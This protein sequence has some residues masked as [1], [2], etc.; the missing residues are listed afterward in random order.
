MNDDVSIARIPLHPDINCRRLS[1]FK[2]ETHHE[3]IADGSWETVDFIHCA[4][5][6]CRYHH[7]HSNYLVRHT[8][9]RI[10]QCT[11]DEYCWIIGDYDVHCCLQEKPQHWPETMQTTNVGD[12]VRLKTESERERER[13]SE[14]CVHAWVIEQHRLIEICE[15]EPVGRRNTPTMI[16]LEWT[17]LMMPTLSIADEH[18]IVVRARVCDTSGRIVHRS[19]R[20]NRNTTERRRR[21]TFFCALNLDV[22]FI[23]NRRFIIVIE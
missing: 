9:L 19:Y 3:M 21:E 11:V 16:A 5:Q 2:K 23:R 14:L 17:S 4:M 20:S 15:V 13:D 10:S 7:H 22:V 12:A 8:L 6:R 1:K 18:L